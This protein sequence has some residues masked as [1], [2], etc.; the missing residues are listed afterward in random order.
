MK[1]G[2]FSRKAKRKISS[3]LL[4]VLTSIVLVTSLAASVTLAYLSTKSDNV[5]NTFTPAQVT[6]K[7][8]EPTFDGSSKGEVPIENTSDVKAYIRAEIV[9]TWMDKDGN[10]L[11]MKPAINV[12][13]TMRIG[14]DWV[15]KDGFYYCKSAVEKG[16]KTGNLILSAAPVAGKNP[17]K[18]NNVDYFL[19]L[20]IICSAIQADGEDAK[21]NKPIELAWGVDIED[22][23]VKTATIEE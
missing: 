13:Y 20:E 9:A 4:L 15:E 16:E 17:Q 5:T 19:S 12:D 21:G 14:A 10:V 11:H 23:A 18:V 2:K 1:N 3:K 6:S 22:G 7:V 8:F